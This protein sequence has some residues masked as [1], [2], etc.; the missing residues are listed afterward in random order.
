MIRIVIAVLAIVVLI[1]LAGLATIWA[2][3]RLFGL[4]IAYNILN[5]LA[6]IWLGGMVGGLSYRND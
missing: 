5:M 1:P 4:E 6:V 3:N 2:V